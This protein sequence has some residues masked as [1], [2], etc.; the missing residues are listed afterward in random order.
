MESPGSSSWRTVNNDDS[1]W[2]FI[3]LQ[4]SLILPSHQSFSDS[5]QHIQS[6]GHHNIKAPPAHGPKQSVTSDLLLKF[7][8]VMPAW[9]LICTQEPDKTDETERGYK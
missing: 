9:I 4:S 2:S 8:V 1:S 5:K 3:S 7:S 6:I